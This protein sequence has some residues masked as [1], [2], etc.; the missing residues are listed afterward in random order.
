MD[1]LINK[2]YTSTQLQRVRHNWSNIQVEH[3][4]PFRVVMYINID[5]HDEGYV[6][7]H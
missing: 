2:Y 3:L 4:Q 7:Y 1:I 5:G 6:R